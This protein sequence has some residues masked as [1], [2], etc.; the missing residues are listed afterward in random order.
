[1]IWENTE[2]DFSVCLCVWSQLLLR[3]TDSL[4]RAEFKFEWVFTTS[5]LEHSP[6]LSL[7]SIREGGELGRAPITFNCSTSIPL[8]H[9]PSQ[10]LGGIFILGSQWR[11]L[12]SPSRGRNV[13]QAN[14]SVFLGGV[15]M[16]QL[17]EKGASEILGSRSH[18]SLQLLEDLF[19]TTGLS[20][21]GKLIEKKQAM[22]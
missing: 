12:I 17:E 6:S 21:K 13:S 18:V 10:T 2:I 7:R 16:G 9:F 8:G 4:K 20:L 14:Q 1:M 19:P 22:K 5:N 15:C 3:I 11:G